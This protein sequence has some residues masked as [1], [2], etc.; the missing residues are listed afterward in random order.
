MG[1]SDSEEEAMP[2]PANNM[3][4]KQKIEELNRQTAEPEGRPVDPTAMGSHEKSLMTRL[5]N[6]KPLRQVVIEA[7]RG[8]EKGLSI[9]ELHTQVLASGY[10][11]AARDFEAILCNCVS[12]ASNIA[13]D[14]TT[15]RCT[16]VPSD[17]I[18][19]KDD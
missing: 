17:S 8:R 4:L 12:Y 1:H 13:Y 18:S 2:K 19:G 10:R 7:L 15:G 9:A 16:L 3:S 5:M 6:A 11:S 14:R